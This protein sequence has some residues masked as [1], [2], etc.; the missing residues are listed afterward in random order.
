MS[1]FFHQNYGTRCD[2]RNLS[3]VYTAITVKPVLSGHLLK[4]RKSLPLF[5]VNLTSIKLS[6]LLSRLD[7]PFKSPKVLILLFS[8]VLNGHFVYKK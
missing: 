6:P 1:D 8:P 3:H 4:S 2:N 7:H 5:T